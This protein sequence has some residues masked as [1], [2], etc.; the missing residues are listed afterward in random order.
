MSRHDLDLI[1]FA[2]SIDGL[3]T[4]QQK[5]INMIGNQ[6]VAYSIGA[7]NNLI[8]YQL[9]GVLTI[10]ANYASVGITGTSFLECS[11]AKSVSFMVNLL[12]ALLLG[13]TQLFLF[14]KTASASAM[15]A[16]T[17]R[18]ELLQF[19]G[20]SDGYMGLSL[21]QRYDLFANSTDKLIEEQI[22]HQAQSTFDAKNI[23]EVSKDSANKIR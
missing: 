2:V 7:V 20:S 11:T 14:D 19:I 10:S 13:L 5:Y 17:V 22:R 4:E 18:W 3:N 16:A 8:M 12:A 9:I 21:Q 1:K 23:A 6:L 15:S